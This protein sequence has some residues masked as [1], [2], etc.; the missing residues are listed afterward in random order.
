MDNIFQDKR[1]N[2]K[3]VLIILF[4]WSFLFITAFYLNSSEFADIIVINNFLSFMLKTIVSIVFSAIL[5]SYFNLIYDFSLKE[6][7]FDF[8]NFNFSISISAAFFVIFF[9]TALLITYTAGWSDISSDFDP[10]YKADS[11]KSIMSGLPLIMVILFSTAIIS[12][13][14][15]FLINKVIFALFDLKFPSFAASILTALFFPVMLFE[16]RPEKIFILFSAVLT[17]NYIYR[18]SKNNLLPAVI[19]YMSFLA[20]YIIFIY[21]YN[22]LI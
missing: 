22:F 14:E 12:A 8:K 13:A 5:Y 2:Y 1:L 3:D 17:A 9:I 21:G 6:L 15:M 10:I 11:I 7:G 20:N 19:F 18:I 16:F 4:I